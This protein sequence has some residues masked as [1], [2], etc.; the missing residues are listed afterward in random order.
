MELNNFQSELAT[1]VELN[2]FQS[3]LAADVS[4][5][6]LITCSHELLELNNLQ[7]EVVTVTSFQNLTTLNRELSELR[8][9]RVS[10]WEFPG[11][12]GGSFL[13]G[14]PGD[15]GGEFP[16][17]KFPGGH[18]IPRGITPAPWGNLQKEMTGL[19][20]G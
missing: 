7:L 6:N 3:E 15:P 19:K 12:M 17:G 1:G 18:G 20:C 16:G 13:A 11:R 10:R 14:G 9:L 5:Q 8:K 2:N 4:F